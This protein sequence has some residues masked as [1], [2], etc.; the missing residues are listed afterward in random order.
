V[1]VTVADLVVSAAAVAVTVAD[2]FVANAAAVNNPD[3]A[4]IVPAAMGVAVHVTVTSLEP[5]TVASNWIVPPEPTV[6]GGGFGSLMEI[7]TTGGAV[8]VSVV[9][10]KLHPVAPFE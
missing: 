3:V 7:E 5:V 9:P 4:L 10:V 2:V 6:V 1:K 8:T